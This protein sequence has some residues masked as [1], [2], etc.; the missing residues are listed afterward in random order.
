M[1]INC[2]FILGYYVDIFHSFRIMFYDL[3]NKLVNKKIY[4][5][6]LI[7]NKNKLRTTKANKQ[8]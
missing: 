4:K 3:V 2:D 7:E 6:N 5:K 1:T 8:K